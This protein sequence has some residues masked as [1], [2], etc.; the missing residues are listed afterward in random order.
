MNRLFT[1]PSRRTRLRSAEWGLDALVL[2]FV[3]TTNRAAVSDLL[4]RLYL[5]QAN[6]VAVFPLVEI[7]LVRSFPPQ[8]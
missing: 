5:E 7:S 1:G 8:P 6:P 3:E 2:W 4:R